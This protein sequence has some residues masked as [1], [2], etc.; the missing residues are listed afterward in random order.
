[1]LTLG[2]DTTAVAA[3]VALVRDGSLL[4]EFYANIGLQHSRT[5]MPMV[6]SMLSCCGIALEEVDR[7]GVTVGPGSFTGVRIGVA[8]IKGLAFLHNK[9]CVGVSTLAMLANNLPP[10]Q[11][12]ICPA[13]DARCNQVYN[14]LFQWENQQLT[15]LCEDRA[16]AIDQLQRELQEKNQPVFWLG[17]GAKLC[18]QALSDC[19]GHFL[20]PENLRYQHAGQVAFLAE[21]AVHTVPPEQ[22]EVSYLRPPQAVRA[23]QSTV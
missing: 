10:T 1:M 12:I 7:F 5:L 23:R 3:S 16:I 18:Y 11:G 22:L 9:P 19:S 14:A 21:R 17:D 20:V 15:R 4:S 6:E 8:A 2:I 13:M